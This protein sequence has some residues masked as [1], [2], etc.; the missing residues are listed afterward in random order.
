MNS[1]VEAPIHVAWEITRRCNSQCAHCS[2][3][4][5]PE[6]DDAG[7][8]S[9]AEAVGIINQLADANVRVLAFSGG[10]PL[11]RPDLLSLIAHANNRGLV[12][13]ICTNGALVD[14]GMARQ[15]KEA[16]LKSVTVSLDGACAQ[17]HDNMR[18]Y[19]G[20]FDLTV[21][22]IRALVGQHHRVGISFTPTVS[23]YQEA[24][25]VA[26]LA[27]S[28][29]TDSICVSQYIP[30]GRGGRDLMLSSAI[31]GNLSREI[32]RLRT[33]Y[34]RRLSV[35]CHDCHVALLLPSEER[36]GYKGCGAGTATAGIRANQTVTPCIFMPNVAGDLHT[37]SFR[38]IWD[39]SPELLTLRDRAQLTSGNCGSCRFKLVCGGCRAA[40]MAIHGNPLAGDPSCWMFPEPTSLADP[41]AR[42]NCPN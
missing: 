22:A 13:N 40:A 26:E 35:H 19:P 17:T 30:T 39:N 15:L 25:Q 7:E 9:T 29:G 2:S 18:R 33:N 21:K 41:G 12:T 16:G 14:D 36:D 20:L 1:K 24:F 8:V 3:N 23:N 42:L 31:L 6:L 11:L 37:D 4:S 32:L 10:E 28:L 34:A 5:G 38:E 27:Y